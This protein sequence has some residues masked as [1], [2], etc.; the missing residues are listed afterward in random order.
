MVTWIQ[1]AGQG[2]RVPTDICCCVLVV[3]KSIWEFK[4]LPKKAKPAAANDDDDNGDNGEVPE[5]IVKTE[6]TDIDLADTT[7]AEEEVALIPAKN[8]EEDL[9]K[10]ILAQTR[11][12]VI[13]DIC[14][15]NPIHD[16]TSNSLAYPCKSYNSHHS[17]YK[18]MLQ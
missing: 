2:G 5:P 16:C 14:F 10:L 6:E 15:C 3:E 13:I 17:L 7:N 8:V 12:Q 9:C 4:K 1:R 11:R 18:Q